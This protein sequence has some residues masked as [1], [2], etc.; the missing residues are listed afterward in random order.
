MSCAHGTTVGQLEEDE[1]FYLRSRGINPEEA[2]RILIHAFAVDLL[3]QVEDP[4]LN[5]RIRAM[6]NERLRTI[7]RT[8]A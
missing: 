1:L 4:T 2:R 8:H 7:N 6:V 5:S 3:D